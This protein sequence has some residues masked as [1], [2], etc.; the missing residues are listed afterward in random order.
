M[1]RYRNGGLRRPIRARTLNGCVFGSDRVDDLQ[2][3]FSSFPDGFPG[4]AL[5]LLRVTVGGIAITQGYLYISRGAGW[6]TELPGVLLV[7]AGVGV[8]LGLLTPLASVLAG[9][10]CIVSLFGLLPVPAGTLF[11]GKLAAMQML[12]MAVSTA[13]LGPGSFS[14]DARLFG[15]REIVI[16]PVVRD[17]E[18]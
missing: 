14:V 11:S 5:L 8:L 17:P 12:V 15:R 13:V 16:P 4:V 3:L 6:N 10:G 1:S 18:A 2:R 9:L 7:L